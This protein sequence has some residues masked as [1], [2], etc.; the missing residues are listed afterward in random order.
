M[1]DGEIASGRRPELRAPEQDYVYQ[2]EDEDKGVEHHPDQ[3]WRDARV[4]IDGFGDIVPY[5]LRR[6]SSLAGE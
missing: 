5:V 1:I 4:S 6:E 3:G 2:A